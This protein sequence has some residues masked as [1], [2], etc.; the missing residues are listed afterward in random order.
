MKAFE[1]NP[2]FKKTVLDNGVRVVTEH[3]PYT[4][5][6]STGL[7]VS[8]GARDEPIGQ[9][10]IAHFIE[11]MVFKG[12]ETR[13]AYEIVRSIE[14]VGGEL[15]AY[16]TQEYTCFHTTTL[17]EHLAL[18]LDVLNDLITSAQFEPSDM[19]KE[20]EVILQEIRMSS[21]EL[22]ESTYDL[23]FELAFKDHE[24]GYPILGTPKSLQGL[25]RKKLLDF[26]NRRYHGSNI[27][28]SVAGHVD[29]D[30]V[31]D[32]ARRTLPGRR[33]TLQRG[34]RRR[35]SLKRVLKAINRPTEQVHILVSLP[36]CSL[37]AKHRAESYIL[38]A[39]LGSGMTSRL[40]QKIREK[41]GLAYIVDSN[42]LPYSDTGVLAIYAATS[43]K[44]LKKVL[45]QI[46]RELINLKKKGLSHSELNFYKKQV[47]GDIILDAD[48]VDSRMTDIALNEMLFGH[49]VNLEDEIKSIEMVS[50]E[51]IQ[52]YIKRYFDFSKLGVLVLGDVTEGP[53][54]RYLQTL[55]ILK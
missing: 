26:Y 39:S 13:D 3:H 47:I 55:P 50:F 18:S 25:T 24:L 43:K 38:N 33:R 1:Y 48:D 41:S 30:E 51:S 17:K 16:T 6:V 32:L 46:S 35:P 52:N 29:H 7:F 12:T 8:Q 44:N 14:A 2:V 22:D 15:N 36:S 23:F 5:S 54:N 11:H 40:F 37:K 20:R 31:V 19:K 45:G 4:R 42:N 28:L 27:I 53:T 9:A 21:E 10:G 34:T 49:Y